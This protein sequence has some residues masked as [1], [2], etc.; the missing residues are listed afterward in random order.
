MNKENPWLKIPIED[1]EAH[2]S[3]P[4]VGQ[5]QM[6]NLIFKELLNQFNPKKIAVVG[7][8]SGNGFE[9]V[10]FDYIDKLLGIDINPEFIN[11]A[12][13]K[14]GD[15]G[16]KIDLVCADIQ[17]YDFGKMKFDLIHCALI[18][19]YISV[20]KV[21]LKSVNSLNPN[22]ILSV[23]LQLA[24]SDK[25]AVSKT[26]YK[27]LESLSSLINLHTVGDFKK[28]AEKS[29]LKEIEGRTIKLK[30]GKEFYFGIFNSLLL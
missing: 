3:S 1:Y 30:S 20:E 27:S 12:K 18:F 13:E 6:L 26:E 16:K 22:G 17:D 25:P 10:D 7:C 24:N 21:L 23:V 19:E 28:I 29:G 14:F 2:M 15:A 5:Q 4:N 9:H 8:T 11:S